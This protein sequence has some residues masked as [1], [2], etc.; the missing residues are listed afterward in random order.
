M[1]LIQLEPIPA[2]AN[3]HLQIAL[4]IVAPNGT[5]RDTFALVVVHKVRIAGA[6]V[7]SH[8]EPIVARF[9]THRIALAEVV[10][11]PFVALAAHLDT[12]Q[13]W[14]RPISCRNLSV[15]WSHQRNSWNLVEADPLRNHA[16][17][18]VHES[19]QCTLG[20]VTSV[21]IGHSHRSNGMVLHDSGRMVEG[22]HVATFDAA[23]TTFLPRF[24]AVLSEARFQAAQSHQ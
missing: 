15:L 4:A 19:I 1:G 2:H 11:V 6:S 13:R 5:R 12:A 3:V 21:Q 23:A 24:Y 20:L 10:D 17:G 16:L 18:F 9:H 8:A 22:H 14:V 7:R